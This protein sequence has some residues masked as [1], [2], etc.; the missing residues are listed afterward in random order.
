MTLSATQCAHRDA[1]VRSGSRSRHARIRGRRVPEHDDDGAFAVGDDREAL[2]NRK[3]RRDDEQKVEH[4]ERQLREGMQPAVVAPAFASPRG[5]ATRTLARRERAHTRWGPGGGGGAQRGHKHV[6][7]RALGSLLRCSAP[8]LLGHH[9]SCIF[10]LCVRGVGAPSS[11]RA[12]ARA[13]LCAAAPAACSYGAGRRAAA[14]PTR[15]ATPSSP[16]CK[17]G[18][19]MGALKAC[20]VSLSPRAPPL[21]SIPPRAPARPRAGLVGSASQRMK[22]IPQAH[23]RCNTTQGGGARE[24]GR[25]DGR[26]PR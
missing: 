4:L 8:R 24:D 7:T 3:C 19:K 14:A 6:R 22:K 5:R 26:H 11:L 1:W 20:G 10:F 2:P 25:C 17:M 23:K 15:A 18:H 13:C 16:H 9:V 12:R 21:P